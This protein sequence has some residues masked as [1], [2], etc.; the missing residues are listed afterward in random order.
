M[1]IFLGPPAGPE[2]QG[3]SPY[4]VNQELQLRPHESAHGHFCIQL[5]M[6]LPKHLQHYPD[7]LNVLLSNPAENDYIVQIYQDKLAYDLE[8]LLQGIVRDSLEGP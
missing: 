7:L 2:D 5:I 8:E 3:L 4:N 6:I 1:A